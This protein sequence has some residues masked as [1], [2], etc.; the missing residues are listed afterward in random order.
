MPARRG[1]LSFTADIPGQVRFT[2]I[3][4]GATVVVSARPE[5]VPS[6]RRIAPLLPLCVAGTATN[7]QA[8]LFQ[9]FW[10]DR[11]RT[12]LVAHRVTPAAGAVQ[13]VG[14]V[15]QYGRYFKHPGWKPMD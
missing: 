14:A 8:E 7:A 9:L 12:L 13:T 2:R 1:L 4:T 15:N 5:G 3:D 10:Q 6:D 11:V